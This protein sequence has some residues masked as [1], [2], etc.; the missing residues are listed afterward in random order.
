M[1]GQYEL[2]EN[3]LSRSS[4][5][6]FL[7]GTA[8]FAIAESIPGG[9]RRAMG[10]TIKTPVR[11]YVGSYSTGNAPEPGGGPSHGKGI[12]LFEMD[13]A[14]GALRERQVQVNRSNPAWIALDPKGTHL[15]AI[16][17]ID[18]FHGTHSGGASAYSVEP[19]SGRLT[20]L[21]TVSTEGAGPAH[22]SVHPSGRYVLV[23]NYDGGSIAVLPVQPGGEL[24]S[25]TDVKH[26]HGHPGSQHATDA[27]PGS[28]ATSGHH[29]PHPHMIRSDPEGRYVLNTDLGLDRIYVWT[30]NLDNG[31]LEPNNP[32]FVSLASG[33]GP[34][35]FVFHPTAPWMYSLQEESSTVTLFDYN[36][37]KGTLAPRQTVSALP[38]GFAGTSFASEPRISSDGKFLYAANRIHDSIAWFS[39][40]D[41]GTLRYAGEEWTRG[42]H[43]RSFA[44]D[45]SERFI[46]SCNVAA[47]A[48]TLFRRSLQSG[49]LTFTGQY[50][51][52]GAP[53]VIVFG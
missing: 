13:S 36:A 25:A 11:A 38:E 45:P 22:L 43:P 46:Y 31:K 34:R 29:A 40:Q 33:D 4:R 15:Y 21:N 23:A 37:E 9:L 35:H 17:E 19:G 27:P 47:D 51:P 41:D 39:I 53:A 7:K 30:L 1:S 50:I 52:V 6:S 28:L 20:L 5:R 2:H 18:N 44:L 49:K 42:S 16:S 26:D 32:H 3:A 14:S 48:I 10:E 24:G 8:A 12:Y